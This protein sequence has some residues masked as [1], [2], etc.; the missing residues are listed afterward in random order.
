MM[1][2]VYR[3]EGRSLSYSAF[4]DEISPGFKTD[5]GFVRRVDERQ[6]F[7]NVFYRWW[8]QNWI[9]NHGPRFS[10]NRNHEFSGIL[11]DQG[12]SVGYMAQFARNIFFNASTD[13]DM[14]RY[15]GVDFDKVRYNFGGGVNASRKISVGGFGSVGDQIR[16]VTDPAVPYQGRGSNYNLFVTVRPISRLQSELNLQTSDFLNTTTQAKEFDIKIYRLQ[17]SYQ[18]TNRMLVRN[19]L[20]YDNYAKKVGVNLLFTYRV[21]SGTVFYV[22]YDGRYQQ[23]NLITDSILTST[24]YTQTNRAIF[25]KLQVLFRY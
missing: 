16:Y 5:S 15:L 4:Y 19:I 12:I 6:I 11:Q 13:R 9:V 23:A 21:N 14:E 8:P 22:G 18:F 3:K 24:D 10:Y 7:T 2:A 20:D 17:T 1:D 25:A